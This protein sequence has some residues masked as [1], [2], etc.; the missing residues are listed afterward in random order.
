MCNIL[1]SLGFILLAPYLLMTYKS[2]N[3]SPVVLEIMTNCFIFFQ[4][5]YYTWF[6][7]YSIFR[8]FSSIR[9]LGLYLGLSEINR[10]VVLCNFISNLPIFLQFSGDSDEADEASSSS[11][12]E[13]TSQPTDLE[14][15]EAESVS[16]V[17][18]VASVAAPVVASSSYVPRKYFTEGVME[19]INTGPELGIFKRIDYINDREIRKFS[20]DSKI[21]QLVKKSIGFNSLY[22]KGCNTLYHICWWFYIV[23]ECSDF[24]K[25]LD[26]TCLAFCYNR[27]FCEFLYL[28]NNQVNP[29]IFMDLDVV[30]IILTGIELGSGKMVSFSFSNTPSL[31]CFIFHY[32]DSIYPL[33][34]SLSINDPDTLDLVG[35]KKLGIRPNDLNI[36]IPG[37]SWIWA[38][39]VASTHFDEVYNRPN[40]SI[41]LGKGESCSL[42]P[43][44]FLKISVGHIFQF[45]M[46]EWV[47]YLDKDF[48]SEFF[49][50]RCKTKLPSLFNLDFSIKNAS[51]KNPKI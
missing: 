50:N 14:A 40:A 25:F 1:T 36:L 39:Q 43:H 26:L 35:L 32:R 27:D 20:V 21:V 46:Q 15:E 28:A 33:Q 41:M 8:N 11:E 17:S 23:Q 19:A 31:F 16:G 34:I 9:N 44:M 49:N 7:S 5:I 6:S 2:N 24:G 3:G 13:D 30:Y 10:P 37:E 45:P 42:A 12:L 51:K 4:L 18:K 38:Y 47:H 29:K 22:T 48:Y